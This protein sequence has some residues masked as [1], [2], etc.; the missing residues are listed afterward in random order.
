MR[1]AL[2]E[3]AVTSRQLTQEALSRAQASN[4]SLNGYLSFCESSALAQADEADRRLKAGERNA[5]LGMPVALKDL[6]LTQ[7]HVT[8]AASKMLEKF[9]PPY[10]ATVSARIKAAGAP[11]IGKTNLDEFAMGSS[12][13]TSIGGACRNPWD[14]TRVPGGSSGG[15][16]VAVA[17]RTVTLSLGTD[18]GGSIRQPS[19]LSGIT[20]LKPTY[21][22]VSRYG[23]VAFASSLD[24]VGPMCSDAV[25]CAAVLQT[26]SGYDVH[27]ATSSRR[28]VPDFVSETKRWTEPGALKGL[29]VGLPRE[30]FAEGLD[31]HVE[32]A[33]RESVAWLRDQGASVQEISLPHT[34]FA[35]PV[36]YLICTSEASSNLARYDG[37]HYGYRSPNARGGSLEDT[38]SLSRGEG[39]GDEV[40]LRILLG[41]FALSSGYYDAYY[42]KA[43]QVRALIRKDFEDA[44]GKCDCVMGPTSPT[45]AFK[46]GEK[47]GDPLRMYLADVYTLSANLAGLPG[48]SFNVGFDPAGLPVGAQIM[49]PWWEEARLLGVAAAYQNAHPQSLRLSPVARDFES[50]GSSA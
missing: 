5:L 33:V 49:A 17:A 15:S 28:P 21:G 36:Y 22:R 42:K 27:D 30:Y 50:V 8:T 44:F 11:I 41:T 45:T 2:D 24:Q 4:P 7:G 10:D 12:N 46:I 48:I 26:I 43:S 40:R 1:V 35:L 31:S 20:G 19:S 29:R 3:G 13:E 39:F 34:R 25:S 23:V 9:V 37:I 32:K 16:A 47:F 6:I 14:T 38:Y 18:T